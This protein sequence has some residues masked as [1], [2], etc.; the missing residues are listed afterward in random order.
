[1]QA[2]KALTAFEKVVA[3]SEELCVLGPQPLIQLSPFFRDT[4][5]WSR[6]TQDE[7]AIPPETIQ[8]EI[9]EAT[10]LLSDL[11][12]QVEPSKLAETESKA[13]KILTGL[14]FS[15]AY[16]S[17]PVSSLSGGWLMRTALA[18]ALLQ[19]TDLLILDEPTNYLDLLGII[20]LQRHL[21]SLSDAPDPPTLI[22]VSHDRD[23]ISQATTDLLILKDKSLTYFHGSLPTYESAQS[24][25]KLHLTKMKEAQDRQKAHIQETI[26]R[27]VRQGKKNDDDNR[28]RQ[29]KSRQKKLDDRWGVQVNAR[30]GRFK[31]NRD[32]AGHHFS[33]REEIEVPADEKG[34]VVGL[35]E[36]AELRFPGP[37]VS[38][39]GIAFR[40]HDP[41][42]STKSGV[43]LPPPPV[44][45]ED[46]TLSVHAGDRVAILGLNGAGK[47]TLIKLLVGSASPTSGTVTVHP[48]LKTGYYSQ[49]A[50]EAL[51]RLSLSQPDLTALSLLTRE[52]GGELDE[53]DLRGLLA[54]LGLAGRTA[55]DVCLG[56][57]SG[58]QLV[59][60]ELA[61]LLWRRPQLL[62]LDEVTT[63]LDYET[64][65]A[66]REALRGWEGAVVLVSHDRWFVRGVVEG[67]VDE[68]EEGG[69]DESCEDGEEVSRRRE[70]YRLNG[71]RLVRLPGGVGE[72][73]E[74]VEKRV[75]KLLRE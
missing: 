10:D 24:E 3:E 65:T 25:R 52:V 33:A 70:V 32:L 41:G 64:V 44:V 16:T 21:Q 67:L 72:F 37:L 18:A 17:K 62:V 12:L 1:M 36:P 48:R 73:E 7:T 66:L 53:G 11:Q 31:L 9:Q 63:H 19:D 4:H 56:K 58:G 54:S 68:D 47:S 60:C 45:L 35:P 61:R 69:E 27:N 22:L 49:H 2:R 30:G 51:Q 71:G 14:G 13:K 26:A 59:R 6:L 40:Y 57:L 55:S 38:L 15:E 46:V 29:A 50:V 42:L 74:G 43:K 34:V 20:W 39:E 75:R 5:R 23:F 28:L 8:K